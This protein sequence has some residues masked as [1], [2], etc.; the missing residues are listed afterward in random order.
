MVWSGQ[1]REEVRRRKKSGAGGQEE[2][3][4]RNR[5]V[6]GGQEAE[7]LRDPPSF[8]ARYPIQKMS[9]PKT[10]ENMSKTYIVEQSL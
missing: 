8:L 3:V 10:T 6:R 4:R 5:S 2:E 1:D 7:V 9:S